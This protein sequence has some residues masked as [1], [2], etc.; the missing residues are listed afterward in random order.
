MAEQIFDKHALTR[1]KNVLNVMT[2]Y[3][4]NFLLQHLPQRSNGLSY[5]Y[6]IVLN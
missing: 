1:I 5:V 2:T 3:L 4:V 6:Q